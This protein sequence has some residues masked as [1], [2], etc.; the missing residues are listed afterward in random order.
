M[1][2]ISRY[3]FKDK[4][5]YGKNRYPVDTA[6]DIFKTIMYNNNCIKGVNMNIQ[7]S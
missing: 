1:F 2:K 7:Y 4:Y 6:P 3:C 5:K